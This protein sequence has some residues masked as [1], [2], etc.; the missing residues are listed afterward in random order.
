MK[1]ALYC[2]T[3]IYWFVLISLS[4]Q[5][6]KI[7][8]TSDHQPY[9]S[10][11]LL[12]PDAAGPPWAQSPARA[13]FL[14]SSLLLYSHPEGSEQ[15]YTLPHQSLVRWRG[16]RENKQWKSVAGSWQS[17]CSTPGL[18][19]CRAWS[20]TLTHP[21]QCNL[22]SDSLKCHRT[23]P[24]PVRTGRKAWLSTVL[25]QHKCWNGFYGRKALVYSPGILPGLDAVHESK[26]VVASPVPHVQ[27][28]SPTF[29]LRSDRIWADTPRWKMCFP[30]LILSVAKLQSRTRLALS[31]FC[32][33][34][35]AC[36]SL[37]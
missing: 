28:L 11:V 14:S 31:C 27:L 18:G 5:A 36:V 1:S 33:K 19:E 29:L 6:E 16:R 4:S 2:W 30:L 12:L 15:L 10:G 25:L 35:N 32:K 7:P 34:A 26:Q 17:S 23:S 8:H 9:K 24:V 37:L 13:A 22:N 21:L 20:W 3:I